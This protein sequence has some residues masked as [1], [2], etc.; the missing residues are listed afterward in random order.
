MRALARPTERPRQVSDLRRLLA[1]YAQWQKQFYPYCDFDTF[2]TKLEK[3][4]R[5]RA[6]KVRPTPRA[7]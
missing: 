3:A 5:K 6:I 7:P 4:G 2:V 1:L